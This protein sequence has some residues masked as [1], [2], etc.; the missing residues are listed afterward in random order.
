MIN[1]ELNQ[2]AL[3]NYINGNYSYIT[4]TEKILAAIYTKTLNIDIIENME[5]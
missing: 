5:E 1:R 4:D 2:S 3:Y